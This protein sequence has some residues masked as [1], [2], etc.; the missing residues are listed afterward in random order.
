MVSSA[1]EPPL[2]RNRH[3][4]M[5]EDS[6]VCTSLELNTLAAEISKVHSNSISHVA[7]FFFL[8]VARSY[9]ERDEVFEILKV[10]RSILDISRI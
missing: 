1:P 5:R 3:G 7:F 8:L 4:K 9:L 10:L 2:E 6:M